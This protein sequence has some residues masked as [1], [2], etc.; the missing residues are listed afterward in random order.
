MSGTLNRRTFLKSG[1]V[2]GTAGLTAGCG[3]GGDGNDG[4]DDGDDGGGDEQSTTIGNFP[5]EGDTA[6]FGFTVPRSGPYQPEGE[7]E[8][9]GYEL[10]VTDLNEGRGWVNASAFSDLS[11]DGLVDKTVDSVTIDTE[12]D[13]ETARSEAERLIT[14]DEVIMFSG[15]SSSAVAVEL[16]D[17]AQSEQVIYM[18]CLTHAN[19]TT[20]T[21]CA[22]YAFRMM[23]NAKMSAEALVPILLEE[24][25]PNPKEGITE[26]EFY[27]LYA[28]YN[29]GQNLQSSLRSEFESYSWNELDSRAVRLGK[30]DYRA[31]LR[32]AARTDPDAV[33]LNL[34]G[35]DGATAVRQ[36]SEIFDEETNV[37]LPLYDRPMAELAGDA[38]EGVY[39]TVA[40]DS[41]VDTTLSLQFVDRFQEEYDRVPDGLAYLAYA[42]TL[43]YASSVA[44]VGTFNPVKVIDDLEGRTY[45][46]GLGK[47]EMRAC[48]HQA[49]RPIPVAR[50]LPAA[51][52]SAGNRFEVIDSYTSVPYDCDEEPAASCDLGA[53]K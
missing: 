4:G 39:G 18:A 10:A 6:T 12:V 46:A 9:R 30:N 1:A 42:Q 16:Q 48:D 19:A 27:Q 31:D 29:W 14:D 3:G 41:T 11:G 45:E 2:L 21:D 13:P 25:G 28:D 40:W 33:F 49:I 38:I 8:L 7:S 22:R 44:R 23:F 51:D 43:L 53:V 24:I 32:R 50:G 5:V 15:G 35:L 20:G 36:A 17:L 52:Q 47:E 37:V 34:F 26:V